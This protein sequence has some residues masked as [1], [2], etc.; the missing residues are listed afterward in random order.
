MADKEIAM[1][2]ASDGVTDDTIIPVYQP[3]ALEAA[4][5]IT[6]AQLL[7]WLKNFFSSGAADYVTLMLIYKILEK[8]VY[9]E[10][11]SDLMEMLHEAIQNIDSDGDDSVVTK[12]S[13]T[14]NLTNVTTS[15][16]STTI[17]KGK[18]YTAI[19]TPKAGYTLSTVSVTMGG[20]NVTSMVYSDGVVNISSVTGNVVI[21][22]TAVVDDA[23]G[24]T[25]GT[26]TEVSGSTLIVF[27]ATYADDGNGN[28][29]VNNMTATDD[30]NGNVTAKS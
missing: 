29:T 18:A 15:N 25:G 7:V 30:G 6:G 14:N 2:P 1:L 27:G 22:A 19:L 12:Y 16:F 13:I 5:H 24:D 8:G 21:T 23:G 10:D 3:G 20:S 11:V 9:T 17:E 26:D 28:V 4:Q